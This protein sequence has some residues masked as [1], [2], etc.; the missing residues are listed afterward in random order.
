MV[1]YNF[2]WKGRDA[3]GNPR[4]TKV[5]AESAQAARATLTAQ[6]WTELE[7]MRDEIA[8]LAAAGV[9]AADWMKEEAMSAEH[10]AEFLEGKGPGLTAQWL[11]SLKESWFT[12]VVF[13]SLLVWGIL[14]HGSISITI[15]TVGLAFFILLVPALHL[16]FTVPIRNYARLNKAKVWAR[17]DEVLQCVER[18]RRSH[19]FTRL[20][21]GEVELVRCRAQAL[22]ALGRLEEGVAEFRPLE[23]SPGLPRWLYLSHLSSIYD[24]AKAYEKSLECRIQATAEKPD[25]SAV[26][27]DLAYGLARSLN[28][29]A[30]ARQALARAEAL[31]ITGM[32]KNYLPFLR[33]IICWREG[34][35]T[36]AKNQLELAV[37]SFKNQQPQNELLEGVILLAK[38]HLCAVNGAL[39]NTRE[40]QALFREV[41]K[42]LVA[43]RENELL[44]A[45]RRHLGR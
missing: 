28:R 16:F 11:G 8:S 5:Q 45:C 21:I 25:S 40:A 22:A 26:W 19:R 18:L 39:G 35:F 14:R 7:L 33:G 42:Y 9:Q 1:E 10:E 41:E 4:N 27:I 23:R 12:L 24:S 13:G 17:W 31:E 37:T 20:G 44:E 36:E 2:L 30:E 6:G 15:G 34:N 3:Q 43:H 32:G 38:S 29:P